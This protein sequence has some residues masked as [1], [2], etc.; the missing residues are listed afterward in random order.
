MITVSSTGAWGVGINR[1]KASARLAAIGQCRVLSAGATDDCGAHAFVVSEP[2][3][4]EAQLYV[5]YRET[6]MRFTQNDGIGMP[7]RNLV[8]GRKTGM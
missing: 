8:A 1:Q 3:L 5:R 6:D 7:R 4:A 2:T